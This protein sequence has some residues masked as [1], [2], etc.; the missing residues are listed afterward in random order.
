VIRIDLQKTSPLT[1]LSCVSHS[2][3]AVSRAVILWLTGMC[4]GISSVPRWQGLRHRSS[5]GAAW[6]AFRSVRTLPSLL[7]GLQ[8]R[9]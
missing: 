9:L 6:M 3:A 1:T 8:F 7:P 5:G 2:M 4:R